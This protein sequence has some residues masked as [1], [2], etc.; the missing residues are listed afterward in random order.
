MKKVFLVVVVSI[1]MGILTG[2]SGKT[3]KSG[4]SSV[5]ENNSAISLNELPGAVNDF[6]ALNYPS[7]KIKNAGHDP[8]CSGEDAMD[9]AIGKAGSPNFSLIF[10]P[11]GKFVQQE[12]DVKLAATPAKI[13]N[14]V[15]TKYPGFTAENGAEKLTLADKKTVHY[16]LDLI[17]EGTSKEVIF[18]ME[19]NVVCEN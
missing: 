9:V 16:Q 17:K 19:G 8:L 18:D 3:E 10:L 2:C 6:I 1:C 4:K 13:L 14:T 11:D 7:Y 15:K 12:E 5:A